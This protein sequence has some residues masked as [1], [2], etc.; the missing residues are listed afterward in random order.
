MLEPAMMR[1]FSPQSARNI[2]ARAER[3]HAP[4]RRPAAI[5]AIVRPSSSIL[6]DKLAALSLLS[7][8]D[9][10][11]KPW[12]A[13]PTST[14]AVKSLRL[15][16]N[17][18]LSG[19]CSRAYSPG[20]G[21][22]CHRPVVRPHRSGGAALGPR[23]P[24]RPDQHVLPGR[25]GGP[26][27]RVPRILPCSDLR[28]LRSRHRLRGARRGAAAR[29]RDLAAPVR[30][31][32]VTGLPA[33]CKPEPRRCPR[34]VSARRGRS[35]RRIRRA[36]IA[37]PRGAPLVSRLRRRRPGG[38]ALRCGIAAP[39]AGSRPGRRSQ[40]VASATSRH[41]FPRP[42]SSTVATA[43]NSE[44]RHGLYRVRPAFG[45]CSATRHRQFDPRQRGP[46]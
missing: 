12:N 24:R 26:T 10:A 1:D 44:R 31:D 19:L 3:E 30:R 37:A 5:D 22:R 6:R 23:I 39:L 27:G 43:S 38:A 21:H 17:G 45:P 14:C 2:K 32:A 41:R 13:A 11:A 4:G 25:S 35:L 34:A 28:D 16:R 36:G 9:P 29:R 40:P 7:G 8:F 42:T 46:A 33:S 15:R 18:G 20:R